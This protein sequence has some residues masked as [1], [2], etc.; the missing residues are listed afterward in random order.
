M[1][2]RT[3]ELCPRFAGAGAKPC[4][5]RTIRGRLGTK[6]IRGDSGIADRNGGNKEWG[7]TR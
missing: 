7:K 2:R 1:S 3:I 4:L 6:L 5:N